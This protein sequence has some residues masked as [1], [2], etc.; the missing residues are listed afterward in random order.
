M[1]ARTVTRRVGTV[2]Y[3]ANQTV[4]TQLTGVTGR[5]RRLFLE[6]KGSLTVAT[7]GTNYAEARNPG[8]LV[9]SLMLRLNHQTVLKQGKWNDWID[10]AKVFYKTPAEVQ[11][12]A[13]ADTDAFRSRIELPFV[14]PMGARPIDTV[15][16]LGPDDRLDLDVTFGD[17]T[18]L[19]NSSTAQSLS[20][21]PTINIIA[22][23][24]A[25]IEG[26]TP[27]PVGIYRETAFETNPGSGANTDYQGLQMTTAR[28]LEYHH[29]IIIQEDAVAN[30]GRTLEGT[31]TDLTLQQQGGGQ[32]SQPVGIISGEQLQH[33]WNLRMA[34]VDSVHTGL[35]P[36][37]FQPAFE[38]RM[39]YN[40]D[41][42]D[43][44]DL[45]FILNYAAPTTGAYFRVL[46]GTIE[47]F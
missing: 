47:R 10:R 14:T 13:S 20:V 15:L 1:I 27:D 12:D 23:M 8:S 43:L 34:K 4:Q 16:N 44:D 30:T 42:S 9:P 26:V 19:V 37:M 7:A 33:D 41:S 18:S 25:H 39:T 28:G 36:V 21:T 38:G 45:R 24:E 17:D 22:E 6:L 32:V 2:T 46:Q 35:Y 5:L 40:L 11:C 3:A 29:L 31:I